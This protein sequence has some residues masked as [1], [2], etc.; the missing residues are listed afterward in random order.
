MHI[1]TLGETAKQTP[2]TPQVECYTLTLR[3]LPG[4]PLPPLQRLRAGIKRLL[5]NHGLRCTRCQPT[6][7]HEAERKMGQMLAAT[8]R[9]TAGRHPKSVTPCNQLTE[10]VPAPTLAALGISKRESAE[11]QTPEHPRD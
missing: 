7:P 2:Q 10:P 6:P 9:A 8:E 5:R 11:A 3:P 4:W 1:R